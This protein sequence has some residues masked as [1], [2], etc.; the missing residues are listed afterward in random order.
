MDWKDNLS[1]TSIR[2]RKKI[3]G[4]RIN[5][6]FLIALEETQMPNNNTSET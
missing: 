1:H 2:K 4:G 6:A 5:H 3:H